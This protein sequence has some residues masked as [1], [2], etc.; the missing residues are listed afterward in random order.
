MTGPIDTAY[1]QVVPDFSGFQRETDHDI[2]TSLNGIERAVRELID[3]IEN[4]FENMGIQ[5]DHVFGNMAHDIVFELQRVGDESARVGNTLEMSIREGANSATRQV[6]Q[7]SRAAS[8]DL[9]KV[10]R[11][12][13]EAGH[14]LGGMGSF[15]AGGALLGGAVAAGAG[16]AQLTTFGL[17]SA[18]SLEQTAIQF[19]ALTGSAQAGQAVLTGLQKFAALTPFEFPD[20]AHAASRFLTFDDAIG[21]SDSDLQS[22]LTTVG[23]VISVTGGG[24][25]ALN[26][27]TLAMG[28][29]ASTGKLT[30]DNLNQI[31][32]SLPGFSGVA[33]IAS[34][35]GETTAQVMQEI[36]K[37]EINASDGIKALLTGMQ[38]FPGAAGAMEAQGQTLLGVFSTFKDTVGQSLAGA[39]E[40]VIPAIK[41][42]LTQITPVLGDALGKIAP[43]IGS[44]I[45]QVLPL[46]GQLVTALVPILQ[47]L[48]KG[49]G[50]AV[51][52]I[53]PALQPLGQALGSIVSALAPVLPVIG[54]LVAD[55]ANGLAPVI[56]ALAPGIS[57]LVGAIAAIATSS[58]PMLTQFGTTLAQLLVPLVGQLAVAFQTI[59]PVIEGLLPLFADL[60]G[61]QMGALVQILPQLLNAFLPLAPV[62][63][64]LAPSIA[65]ILIALVPLAQLFAQLALQ[66]T[67]FIVAAI[68]FSVAVSSWLVLHGIIPLIQSFANMLLLAMKPISAL[69]GWLTKTKDGFS[70]IDFGGIADAIGG[71]FSKAWQVISDFFSKLPG[72]ILSFIESLPGM[73]A[74]LFWRM[75]NAIFYVIGF[76]IGSIIREIAALPGQLAAITRIALDVVVGIFHAGVDTAKAI[77]S[78]LWN[79][80]PGLVWRG[81]KAVADTVHSGIDA[82]VDF[83]KSLP[84]RAAD[85]ARSLWTAIKNATSDIVAGAESIGKSIIDGVVSGVRNGASVL[86]DAVK[87]AAKSALDGAKK[88]LGINSPSKAFAEIG[89]NTM[90]GFA[91]GVNQSA[92]LASNATTSALGPLADTSIMT[93]SNSTANGIVFG[94][95]AI[96]VTLGTGAT[97]QDAYNAGQQVAAGISDGLSS[98]ASALYRRPRDI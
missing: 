44:I 54:Q 12:A 38:Q 63:A 2:S 82:V 97:A 80:L 20:V 29:I 8:S 6:D 62:L 16:L 73:A 84:G 56:I 96:N 60:I 75:F 95:G 19:K 61:P 33:A 71:A 15:L 64:Q 22:F 24:A 57:A 83:I 32:E 67:P 78:W 4:R 86:I 41:D 69:V 50:D 21:I 34:A 18:A 7:F 23:N 77:I 87:N 11:K 85:A 9:E 52:A 91:L 49:L 46:A 59:G 27:V 74:D 70:G 76:G 43:A 39:F 92:G 94:A 53:G 51:V 10:D 79:D 47:P 28:Q 40:P 3:S 25:Q 98:D 36:S 93:T 81:I 14:S 88:A 5:I 13:T 68:Q 37:G 26:T 45:S 72:E 17:Q 58:G 30:L 31:S 48:L 42:A 1:V 55:L 66:M 65:Q 90:Q 35:R 89:A